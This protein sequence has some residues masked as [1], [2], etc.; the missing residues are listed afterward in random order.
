[1]DF[2]TGATAVSMRGGPIAASLTVGRSGSCP[3]TVAGAERLPLTGGTALTRQRQ[4]CLSPFNKKV[5]F[6]RVTGEVRVPTVT[7]TS[8]S[9][10]ASFWIGLDGYQTGGKTVEQVGISTDCHSGKPDYQAWWEMYP[11]G[12]NYKF[13]VYPGDTISMLV[14]YIGGAWNLALT[15]LTRDDNAHKFNLNADCPS[16]HVCENMTAEAILEADGGKNLSQFTA[17]GFTEVKAVDSSGAST[18]L[19]ADGTF[20]GLAK[21]LMT[22]SNGLELALPEPPTNSG[23]NYSLTYIEAN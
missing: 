22:G 18:G 14:K 3:V 9:S 2:L 21:V 15:D 8:S 20:W 5:T 11:N 6:V 7:C 17:T 12:T 23:E 4:R 10:K 16:G 13:T 19:V 1:M